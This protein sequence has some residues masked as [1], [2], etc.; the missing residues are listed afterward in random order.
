MAVELSDYMRRVLRWSW[1][2]A[3]VTVVGGVIAL[4]LTSQSATNYVTSATVAPPADVSTAAAAQQYV[5][6]FQAAS[7]SRAVQEAVT[8]ET[9]VPRTT[10]GDRVSVNRVGDSGLVSVT[11]TTPINND[12]KAEAV[13]TS[14]VRNTLSLM[15]ETR[16]KAA[17]RTVQAADDSIKA[18]Q[19]VQD[20]N[21]AQVTAFLAARNYISPASELTSVE[22]QLTQFQIQET[23][24]RAAANIASANTF[25]ARV[26]ELTQRRSD[27]GKDNIAYGSLL[28]NV[29]T[30]KLQVGRA[31]QAKEAA[32][33]NQAQITPEGQ[34]TFGQRNAAEDR[35][36]TIWRRTLAVMLACFILSVLLVAWLSSLS[37]AGETDEVAEAG[38]IP[39]DASLDIE[40]E[41]VPELVPEPALRTSTRNRTR[42]TKHDPDGV[43]V[44]AQPS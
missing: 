13:V 43:T 42:L 38:E 2:I 10:I 26:A 44:S 35:A 20:A 16:V 28:A 17:D 7:G 8:E 39:V 27:L 23:D 29:D 21:E 3:V 15:Y 25:A 36:G 14:V 5:N 40:P 18:A 11:Y 12:P 34:T 19:A 37:P 41:L 30:A 9:S 24:A 31:Q 32:L 22:N 6:D 33:A 1:L 4:L